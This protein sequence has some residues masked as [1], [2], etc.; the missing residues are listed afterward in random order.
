MSSRNVQHFENKKFNDMNDTF[1]MSF[2]S[3]GNVIQQIK[4]LSPNTC[5]SFITQTLEILHLARP[6]KTL[7]FDQI[8]NSNVLST[9]QF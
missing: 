6:Y 1:V 3:A 2:G 5:Y 8:L 4:Q 7:V 9:S